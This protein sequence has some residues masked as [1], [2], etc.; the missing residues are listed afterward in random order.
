MMPDEGVSPPSEN[1][2]KSSDPLCIH[3]GYNLRGLATDGRCPEC[4]T[5]IH[6]SIH[7]DLLSGADPTWLTRVSRGV[8]L[9]Y[10]AVVTCLASIVLL[11]L[12]ILPVGVRGPAV[13]TVEAVGA[14]LTLLGAILLLLGILGLTTPDPRLTLTEQPVA[15]R[16]IVRGGAIA[17]L[18]IGLLRSGLKS[19]ETAGGGVD[20]LVHSV[21]R[22]TFWCALGFTLVGGS[23]YLAHLAERI[24][25]REAA[26]HFKSN[27]RGFAVCFA[28]LMLVIALGFALGPWPVWIIGAIIGG[29]GTLIYGFSLSG[30][31]LSVRKAFKRCLIE[32]RKVEGS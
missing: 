26:K 30:E 8:T 27:A 29:F 15:L 9:I 4:G 19:L 31:W 18:L 25:D 6:H 21:A 16:R 10:A 7:G 17:G 20:P 23:L 3:C 32:A 2:D 14:F 28:I 11:I 1:D 22:W 5:P 13:Y 24:P 12:L